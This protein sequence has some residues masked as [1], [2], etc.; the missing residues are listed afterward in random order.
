MFR[1]SPDWQ[2]DAIFK[3]SFHSNSQ[4]GQ[5]IDSLRKHLLKPGSVARLTGLSGLGK[6]RLAFE[7]LR[8]PLDVSDVQQSILSSTTVYLDMEYA[9]TGVL[10]LVNEIEK[11]GMSGTVVVDNSR[12]PNLRQP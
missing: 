6:T 10:A 2:R 4:L 7:S 12:V 9:P 8:P 5:C 3:L 1:T 11:A